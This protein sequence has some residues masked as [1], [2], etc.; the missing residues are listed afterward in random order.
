MRGFQVLGQAS[1]LKRDH[2]TLHDNHEFIF[3]FSAIKKKGTYG[4]KLAA[5][6]M[7]S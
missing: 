1:T 5:L 7:G 4:S 2:A 6:Q 3:K